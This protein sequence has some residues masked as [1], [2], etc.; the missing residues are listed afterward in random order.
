MINNWVFQKELRRLIG[1]ILNGK[2]LKF[3]RKVTLIAQNGRLASSSGF[4]NYLWYI[5]WHQTSV[6]TIIFLHLECQVIIINELFS[7]FFILSV[8][9]GMYVIF[10]EVSVCS[11][12]FLHLLPKT[13]MYSRWRLALL[14]TFIFSDFF[15]FGDELF[16][17][18]SIKT[19]GRYY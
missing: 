11:T 10:F 6:C 16:A 7:H 14:S 17:I 8:S 5:I 1:F 12:F 2:M 13:P 15:I 3:V 18:C 9:G 19:A 4:M